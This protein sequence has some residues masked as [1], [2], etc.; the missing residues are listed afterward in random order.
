MRSILILAFFGA[1]ALH[2]QNFTRGVGAY[3][4]AP[5]ENFSPTLQPGGSATRNLALR[6]PAYHSSSYDYCLTAQL[7]T[8]GIKSA[9]A[10]RWVAVSTSNKGLLKKNERDWLLDQNWPSALTFQ[11][12]TAWIQF[13]LGGQLP[14]IDAISVDG[15]VSAR[16]T[17]NQQWD[18]QVLTSD[19]GQNWTPAGG[20]GGLA[21]PTGEIRG[22]ASLAAPARSR[23]YRLVFFNAR[24][25]NWKISDVYFF[26][27]GAKVYIGGPY[28]F[29]SAWKSAGAGPGEEWVYVDLGAQSAV[30]SVRLS[31]IARAQTGSL[32]V[33]NDA[34]SWT[35]VHAP[36]L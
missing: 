27:N 28:S 5:S 32:Q 14:E 11:G 19:D 4:G 17:D 36:R 35:D 7:V 30:D 34:R 29:T 8:D 10:P 26:R 3:P 13:E 15:S 22:K 1:S 18:L 23:F 33:S 6:R 24:P 25:L 21:R 12:K 9:T 20:S 16:Q 31:W 2:S